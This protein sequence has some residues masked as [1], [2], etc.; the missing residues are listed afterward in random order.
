MR[1]R[2]PRRGSRAWPSCVMVYGPDSERYCRRSPVS[3]VRDTVRN[4]ARR[5]VS[6]GRRDVPGLVVEEKIGFE[7]AEELAF[8]EAPQEERLVDLDVPIHQRADRALVSRVRAG[9]HERGT[10]THRH[11]AGVFR[12]LQPMEGGEQRLE[13]TRWQWTRR[14]I[15]FV[16][17]KG[18]ESLVAIETLRLVGKQHG[19]A[20]EGDAHFVG[21]RI[22][23]RRLRIDERR[24]KVR[25]K[26]RAHVVG[27]GR[28]KEVRTQ[29][30][31][32]LVRR[33]PACEYAALDAEL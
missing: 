33:T 17:L 13:R 15:G 21:M 22:G 6:R 26:R 19:V 25:G 10:K 29:R 32:V 31:Q 11:L 1:M 28:E 3:L 12:L 16:R 4:V 30:I 7:R 5:N 9:S 18:F 24:R 8:L 14:V 2:M 23:K 27:V 20:V